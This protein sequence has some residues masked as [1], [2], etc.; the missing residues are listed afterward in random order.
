MKIKAI[1]EALLALGF[2]YE[3]VGYYSHSADEGEGLL[4]YVEVVSNFNILIASVEKE[5]KIAQIELRLNDV[6]NKNKL[7]TR[8][9]IALSAILSLWSSQ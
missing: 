5:K 9:M 1:H 4:L 2:Q 8:E 6:A 7:M 3:D